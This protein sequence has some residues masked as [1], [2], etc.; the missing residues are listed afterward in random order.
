MFR[1]AAILPR[2]VDAELARR[3]HT[4][5]SDPD[6]AMDPAASFLV[7]R[8]TRAAVARARAQTARRRTR[9]L[10]SVRRRARAANIISVPT[11]DTGFRIAPRAFNTRSS[12]AT[13]WIHS[14]ERS[15]RD[16]PFPSG[17]L[18]L[19]SLTASRWFVHFVFPRRIVRT[20]EKKNSSFLGDFDGAFGESEQQTEHLNS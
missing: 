20:E 11:P 16:E 8:N 5:T 10:E 4:T 15:T 14:R 6:A 3:L 19:P 7:S 9:A 18:L 1:T 13:R 2:R 12:R 17:G